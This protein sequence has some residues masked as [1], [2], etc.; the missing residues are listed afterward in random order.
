[1]EARSRSSQLWAISSSGVVVLSIILAALVLVSMKLVRENNA[2]SASDQAEIEKIV[3]K[4]NTFA[5]SIR[6]IH[7]RTWLLTSPEARNAELQRRLEAAG[8]YAQ[9][10]DLAVLRRLEAAKACPE[11]GKSD[12]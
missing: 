6:C 9:P 2:R 10:V 5:E 12:H 1:M 4:T 3:S 8:L 11:P 7:D